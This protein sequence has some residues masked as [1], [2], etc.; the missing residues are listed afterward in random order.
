M[1]S[2]WRPSAA[3]RPSAPRASTWATTRPSAAVRHLPGYES[4]VESAGDGL[5]GYPSTLIRLT[6]DAAQ[7]ECAGKFELFGT[8]TNGGVGI[9]GDLD[10]YVVDVENKTYVVVANEVG[11]APQAVR[12]EQA[13]V[14]SSVEFV[15]P[16]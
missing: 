1:C 6:P 5:F 2:G 3:S 15:V 14:L 13:G 9:R 12:D 11:E 4:S 10:V 7:Q 8:D 16:D